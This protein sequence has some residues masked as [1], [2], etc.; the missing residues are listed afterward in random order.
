MR[1]CEGPADRHTSQKFQ[2]KS[3]HLGKI[4]IRSVHSW[5]HCDTA[6][7]IRK[8]L[9]APQ[10]D[11]RLSD[12]PVVFI[13][14]LLTSQSRDKHQPR[15]SVSDISRVQVSAS[16][17]PWPPWHLGSEFYTNNRGQTLGHSHCSEARGNTLQCC[18][19]SRTK[20]QV[21]HDHFHT[22]FSSWI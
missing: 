17:G 6:P 12:A 19:S 15:V 18:R 5:S 13:N 9:C 14:M 22:V 21:P 11:V 16:C 7:Y 2:E 4:W 10:M 3:E 1:Q 20:L 8:L